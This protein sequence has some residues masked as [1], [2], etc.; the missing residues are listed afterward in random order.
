MD[1]AAMLVALLVA[2]LRAAAPLIL[3]GLG[4]L[5]TE[6]AGVLNLGLP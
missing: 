2:T 6:R 3:A 5:I 1:D 4:E